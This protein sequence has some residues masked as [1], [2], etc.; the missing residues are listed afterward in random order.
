VEQRTDVVVEDDV[1]QEG[2]GQAVPRVVVRTTYRRHDGVADLFLGADV[3]VGGW[4][5][6]SRTYSTLAGASRRAAREMEIARTQR[7]GQYG[8]SPA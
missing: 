4:R 7:R 3:F 6:N 1:R 8:R 2:N 5:V